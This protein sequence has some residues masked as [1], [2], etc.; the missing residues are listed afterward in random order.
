VR[1]KSKNDE[2]AQAPVH[3]KKMKL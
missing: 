1:Q 3:R 2:A